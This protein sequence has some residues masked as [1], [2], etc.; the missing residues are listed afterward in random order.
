[1][2]H[3]DIATTQRYADYAPSV[4]EHAMVERAWA[5]SPGLGSNLSSNLSESDVISDDANDAL[6]PNES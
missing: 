5:P 1:M 3:R 2:G 4:H 6:E